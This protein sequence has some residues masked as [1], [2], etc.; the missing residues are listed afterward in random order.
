MIDGGY[1]GGW[2]RSG[3]RVGIELADEPRLFS[4][5]NDRMSGALK[6]PTSF[7]SLSY[8]TA[9]FGRHRKDCLAGSAVSGTYP[10]LHPPCPRAQSGNDCSRAGVFPLDTATQCGSTTG[11]QDRAM[12]GSHTPWRSSPLHQT[13]AFPAPGLLHSRHSGFV[14]LVTNRMR[15]HPNSTTMAYAVSKGRWYMPSGFC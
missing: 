13:F 14:R 3:S 6:I 7:S 10:E 5:N 12:C 2:S 11:D 9:S 15:P 8:T 1:I 4:A